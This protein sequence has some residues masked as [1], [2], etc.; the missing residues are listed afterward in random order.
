MIISA[1]NVSNEHEAY[2][3]LTE[4]HVTILMVMP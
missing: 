1:K 2:T 4:A 3:E